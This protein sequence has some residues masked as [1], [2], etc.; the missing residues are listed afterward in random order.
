MLMARLVPACRNSNNKTPG[1]FLPFSTPL[2]AEDKHA[3]Y[4]PIGAFESSSL[5]RA[6]HRT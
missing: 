3:N 5:R 6:C 4:R 2:A 1:Y